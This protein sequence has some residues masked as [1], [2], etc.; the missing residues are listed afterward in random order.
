MSK[1]INAYK[2]WT[3]LITP[4]NDDGS[5]DWES[6]EKILRQQ[7]TAGNA[8]TMLGST[9]EALN[10]DEEEK[11]KIL[12]LALGL[13]LSAPIMVGVGGIHLKTQVEWIK[14]LNT[15]DVDCYLLVVPLYAKPG[16][17]G[18]YGWFKTLMDV[19]EK[20]CML[21]NIPG[22][23]AKNLELET[24]SML[25]DHPNFWGIKEASGSEEDF[26]EYIKTAPKA[27]MLSGDD[28]MLPA[29]AKL[30]AKGVVSVASNVWPEATSEYAE[31]C[32]N[33]TFKD[34][35]IW[36]SACEALFCASN[37]VP[38]KALMHDLGTIKSAKLRLPL[39]DKDMPG[40][41][42][43]READKAIKAWFQK[44]NR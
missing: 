5:V 25:K 31:Q 13:K 37:P 28:P 42:I 24:L 18:Q 38:V 27:Q 16:V 23:T 3:A 36:E 17:K 41:E 34:N 35:S 1:D 10:I 44:N 39:S 4:M 7:E 9:G 32:V 12:E 40:V 2:V 11:K 21:Y 29:F 30:G 14:Y 43:V 33:G 26:A 6:L 15:L 22:R 8:L 19:A 20:P